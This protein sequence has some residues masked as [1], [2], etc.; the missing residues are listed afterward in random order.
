M[1]NQNLTKKERYLLRKQEKENRQ[2]QKEKGRKIKKMV[3]ILL[4]VILVAG[5]ISFFLMN[6]SPEKS[7][8]GQPQIEILETEYDAGTVSMLEDKVVHIYEI[9]NVGTGNLEIDKIWTS[10]MCTT[11]KLKVGDE[12]SGEFG[13]HTNSIFWSQKIAPGQTGFLEVT[14][15]QAFHGSEG[16]GKITRAVYLSTDDPQKKQVEVKLIAEVTQ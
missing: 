8:S 9:K 15:D 3:T 6:Y 10:C 16:T 2:I 12:E 1:D 14:F 11:A 13:M 7:N 4:P 5:G